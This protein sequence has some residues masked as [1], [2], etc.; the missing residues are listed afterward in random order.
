MSNNGQLELTVQNGK[1]IVVISKNKERSPKFSL[2]N[3]QCYHT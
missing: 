3:S 2:I 1:D